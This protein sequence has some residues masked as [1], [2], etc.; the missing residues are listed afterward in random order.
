MCRRADLR[1]SQRQRGQRVGPGRRDRDSDENAWV[2]QGPRLTRPFWLR[3]GRPLGDVSEPGS[4]IGGGAPVVPGTVPVGCPPVAPLPVAPLP[5]AP[6]PV[7][8]PPGVPLPGFCPWCGGM[9]A[10]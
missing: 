3:G 4:V 7:P 5:V 10:V 9:F 8:V 1:P 2:R 6:P